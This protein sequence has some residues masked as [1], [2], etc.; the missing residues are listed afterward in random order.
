LKYRWLCL[1][2]EPIALRDRPQSSRVVTSRIDVGRQLKF[3]GRVPGKTLRSSC[4]PQI[5]A[6]IHIL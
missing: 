6:V 3:P 4:E 5:E 2:N 1:A